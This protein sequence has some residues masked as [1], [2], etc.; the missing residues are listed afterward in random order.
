MI[1]KFA[2]CGLLYSIN[3]HFEQTIRSLMTLKQNENKNNLEQINI[4]CTISK[5]NINNKLA[6]VVLMFTS[7]NMFLICFIFTYVLYN[8][9][10]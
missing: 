8:P 7:L 3:L 1:F 10:R 9:V 4:N 6:Q 5:S 2:H